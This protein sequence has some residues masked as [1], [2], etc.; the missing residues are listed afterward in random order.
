MIDY[1]ITALPSS[2]SLVAAV[3]LVVVCSAVSFV[4]AL[5]LAASRGQDGGH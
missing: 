3:G 5:L 4:S 2:I 1:F